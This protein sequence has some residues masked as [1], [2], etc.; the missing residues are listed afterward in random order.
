MRSAGVSGAALRIVNMAVL[1][2]TTPI[3]VR[4]LGDEI[5]GVFVTITA[6]T[7]YLAMSDL[8]I[9]GGL[10]ALGAAAG[11]GDREEMSR[12]VTSAAWILLAPSGALIAMLGL[13]LSVALD[14]PRLLGAPPRDSAEVVAAFRIFVVGFAMGCPCHSERG[15][16][17]LC[18][19]ALRWRSGPPLL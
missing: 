9:G 3:L 19:M 7:A 16:S 10:L 13:A 12:L 4:A 1:F 8:G 5:F 2:V 18:S 15:S 6:L 17:H 11:R 14:I